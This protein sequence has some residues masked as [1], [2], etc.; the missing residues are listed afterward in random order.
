MSLD[1]ST[2][3]TTCEIRGASIFGPGLFKETDEFF[4]PADTEKIGSNFNLYSTGDNPQLRSLIK[5]GHHRGQRYAQSLGFP[6]LGRL[7]ELHTE[8]D[9]RVVL[10]R[11]VGIPRIVGS[12]INSGFLPSISVE[13][14][15]KGA[16]RPPE[17]PNAEIDG[18]VLSGIALLGEELPGVPGFPPPQAVFV[19]GTPV[20][21]L[22]D[23]EQIWWLEHMAAIAGNEPAGDK[24]EVAGKGRDYA[25]GTRSLCFSALTFSAAPVESVSMD[26]ASIVAALQADPALMEQVLAMAGGTPAEPVPVAETVPAPAVTMSGS[27]EIRGSNQAGQKRAMWAND[28]DGGP[29][30]TYSATGSNQPGNGPAGSPE[31]F[32][33][34][35]AEMKT[36]M[37]SFGTRLSAIEAV[38]S[39][40][41]DKEKEAEMSAFSAMVDSAWRETN[42]DQK[43]PPVVAK[44]VKGQ[45]IA[46]L[47]DKTFASA[48]IA[49][50]A[51]S[52]WKDS[53]KAMPVNPMLKNAVQDA[54]KSGDPKSFIAS[55]PDYV[56]FLQSPVLTRMNA[57]A[58]PEIRK[59]AG[60]K[61]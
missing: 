46:I 54:N 57:R 2:D 31:A 50:A 11:A 61:V 7:T 15:P 17:D 19:D 41:K 40:K 21:P 10:D 25:S 33:A 55:N 23:E 58:I 52:E 48:D 29:H 22:T 9:G 37:S 13:L 60:V 6:S 38:E 32:A 26:A 59:L 51:F 3:R 8:P 39:G 28:P 30:D 18:E 53:L 47:A 20:P 43:I 49:T 24:T 42:A 5:I 36:C 12:A 56:T 1:P 16:W 44:S 14:P 27:D 34:F 35:A 4:S 45:G